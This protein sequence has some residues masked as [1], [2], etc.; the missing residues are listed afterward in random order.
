M[1]GSERPSLDQKI[2]WLCYYGNSIPNSIYEKLDLAILDPDTFEIP[3]T[4]PEKQNNPWRIG[5]VSIGETETYRWYWPLVQGKS[6][7]LEP[8]PNWANSYYVDVRSNEWQE[9]LLKKVIPK[10]LEKGYQ[11]IFLD[12]L[13]T[14]EYLEWKD[15]NKYAGSVKALENFIAK[16]REKFPKALIITNNGLFLLKNCGNLIDGALV[17]DIYTHYNFEKKQYEASDIDS[18]QKKEQILVPFRKN[19]KKPLYVLVYAKS[20][21]TTLIKEGLKKCKEADFYPYITTIDLNQIG[22]TAPF[23]Q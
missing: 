2:K 9:L 4:E 15:K 18:D 10:I 11:G 20:N 22:E 13:D 21:Q 3:E 19:N 6:F 1:P 12:T 7:V 23:N 14:A 16:L 17:E 5:Y 8:N